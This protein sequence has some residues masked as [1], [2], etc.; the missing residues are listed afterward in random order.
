MQKLYPNLNKKK[1]AGRPKEGFKCALV[2]KMLLK[3][4]PFKYID[5]QSEQMLRSAGSVPDKRPEQVVA[6]G[7]NKEQ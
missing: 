7:E 4:G 1:Q 2:E 3:L 5:E 6:V